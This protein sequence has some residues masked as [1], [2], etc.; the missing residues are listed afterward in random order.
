MQRNVWAS[1][2]VPQISVVMGPCAGGAV[3]SPALTDFTFMVEGSG[4]CMFVTGPDVVKAVTGE[5][6]TQAQLGGPEV[7]AGVSGVAH[8]VF[9]NDMEA[10][11]GVREFVSLLPDRWAK[12]VTCDAS[13]IA[14]DPVLEGL[15]PWEGN[16]G[17]DVKDVIGRLIDGESRFFELMPAWAQN[18]VIGLGTMGGQHVGFVANQPLVASGALDIAAST[19]AARWVRF[20]DAFGIPLVTLVDVPGFLPGREQEHG[21]IIRH[22]AKLLFAYAEATTPK[23]TV[24]LRKAYGGAY[25]VMSSKHLRGDCNYAWP[26]AEIA[27]MGARGAVE[28]LNRSAR[29]GRAAGPVLEEAA[30]RDAFE[31]PFPAAERGYI[32]DVILPGSTRR[33]LIR[34]LQRLSAHAGARASSSFKHSNIPL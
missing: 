30:Y 3:Y 21:G 11:R 18:I 20:C 34:D 9:P 27:V 32:D 19:K 6:I 17:Y 15:V 5:T 23:L 16:Q 8:G 33:V 14:D 25:D 2:R 22:G 7:H 26:M 28:I 10:L 24:I 13:Q 4:S 31:S 29:Q 12:P 1:G